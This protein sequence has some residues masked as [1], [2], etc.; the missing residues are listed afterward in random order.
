MHDLVFAVKDDGRLVTAYHPNDHRARAAIATLGTPLSDR[1]VGHVWPRRRLVRWAFRVLRRIFGG[2]GWVAEWTRNW[3][4]EWI[5]VLAGSGKRL[6]GVYASHDAAV[7]A[8][9]EWSL[10]T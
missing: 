9:I 8:E 3:G 1:R 6:P 2:D 5:V 10:R 4:G 7:T